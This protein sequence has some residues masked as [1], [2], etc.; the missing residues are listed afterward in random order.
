MA[1]YC[2][3]C[4]RDLPTELAECPRCR[5]SAA[6][7]PS[8]IVGLMLFALVLAGVLTHDVRLC[9]AG[10]ALAVV[11]IAVRIAALFRDPPRGSF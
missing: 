9:L 6:R 4:F 10:A 7:S 8:L 1:A 3:S 2:K 11:T 5:Q